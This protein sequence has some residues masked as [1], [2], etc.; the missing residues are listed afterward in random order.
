MSGLRE[1]LAKAVV[2]A[3]VQAATKQG[4]E[5][6]VVSFSSASNAMESGAISCDADGIKRLLDFLTY[7]FGGGTDVTGALH[8][9]VSFTACDELCLRNQSQV[10]SRLIHSRYRRLM[11]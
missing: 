5:C 9:A 2:V 8:F 10:L 3:S 4:R 1:T 11:H 7:S 6:R